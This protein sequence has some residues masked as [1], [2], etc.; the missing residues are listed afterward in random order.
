[1]MTNMNVLSVDVEDYFHVEA[2][3]GQIRQ[4]D[5]STYQ[6][7]VDRNVAR[8]LELFA[9]HKTIGT[10]FMLGW[11]AQRFPNMAREIAAAGHEIGC[12]GFAH[13]RLHRITPDEF[14]AD[15]RKATQVLENQIQKPI[16]CY[17]AP[18]FSIV[19][20]TLWAFDILAEEGYTIDSSVFPVRH[21]LYGVPDGQRFPYLQTTPSGN[22]VFEFPPSTIRL[23]NM[24]WGVAGG[25]YL[26][27]L[28]YGVTWRA[29][30][31]INGA[32]RQPAMVYFHPWEIDPDQPR[33]QTCL[34]SSLRHYTNLSGMHRKIDR[35]LQEFPFTTLS[36]AC[37]HYPAVQQLKV[38]QVSVAR[39]VAS[40]R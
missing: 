19:K 33:I 28:P 22:Q 30:R 36:N 24:N 12:H 23:R 7:R 8:I 34:R 29:L 13:Q 25:G 1:M 15:L 26:R 37:S 32:E 2:F 27:L 39:R 11:V 10:F 40:G 35:L 4:R 9:R 21:D 5:W 18:S 38:K 17:R 31:H 14:R 20:S 6:P 3:V 16:R